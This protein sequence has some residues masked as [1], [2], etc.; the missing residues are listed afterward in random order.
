MK[1]PIAIDA[2]DGRSVRAYTRLGLCNGYP[3]YVLLSP[4]G[5]VLLADQALPGPMLRRFK[6][7]LIRAAVMGNAATGKTVTRASE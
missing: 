3:S 5:T 2:P 4:Q 6:L 1:F 7:E